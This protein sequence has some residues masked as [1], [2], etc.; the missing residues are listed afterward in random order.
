MMSYSGVVC[1]ARVMVG[2]RIWHIYAMVLVA[3]LSIAEEEGFR[4]G[5]L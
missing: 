5:P 2:E 4:I 3:H 1:F